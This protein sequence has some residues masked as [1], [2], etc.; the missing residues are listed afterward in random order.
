MLEFRREDNSDRDQIYR[1]H[2][3]AFQRDDEAQLVEKLRKNNQFNSHLSFVA[4]VD[5]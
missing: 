4:L 5:K 1:I 3:N 2:Q